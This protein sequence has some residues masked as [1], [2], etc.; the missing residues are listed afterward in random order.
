MKDREL[1]A[2]F[3]SGW[4]HEDW[5]LDDPDAAAVVRRYC[6]ATRV[7]EEHRRVVAGIRALV[8]DTHEEETLARILLD[9]LGCTVETT[10]YAM[11]ARE[12]MCMIADLIE[13]QSLAERK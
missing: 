13:T 12:W 5:S 9:E 7:P 10:A 1:L 2:E 3:F 8:A 11:S 6:S 4:F